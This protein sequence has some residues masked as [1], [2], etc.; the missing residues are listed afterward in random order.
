MRIGLN[1]IEL[2]LELGPFLQE[3]FDDI[4]LFIE[5]CGEH[6]DFVYKF[7]CDGFIRVESGGAFLGVRGVLE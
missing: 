1:A 7:G 3:S 4:R 5:L 2:S 6:E